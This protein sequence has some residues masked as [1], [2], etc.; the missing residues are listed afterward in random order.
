VEQHLV[1]QI[2]L[3]IEAWRSHSDTPH[4]IVLLWVSDQPDAEELYLTTNNIHMHTAGFQPAVPANERPQTHA[5]DHSDTGISSVVLC[6][7]KM[8]FGTKVFAL[9]T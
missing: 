9:E 2:F 6:Q 4:S 3:I 8:L 7:E 5:L 1:G